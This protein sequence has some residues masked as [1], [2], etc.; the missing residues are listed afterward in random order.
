MGYSGG[1]FKD[2]LRDFR[3]TDELL[4]IAFI[5]APL[6]VVLVWAGVPWLYVLPVLAVLQLGHM[7]NNGW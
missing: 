1:V 4:W 3:L 6:T 7:L 2:Y 5:L